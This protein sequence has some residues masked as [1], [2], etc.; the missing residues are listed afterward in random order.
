[1]QRDREHRQEHTERS[2]KRPPAA[3]APQER[4][5]PVILGTERARISAPMKRVRRRHPCS[6][7]VGGSDNQNGH[8]DQDNNHRNHLTPM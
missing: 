2:R 1:V 4:V 3:S 5:R 8:A 7:Y 6:N